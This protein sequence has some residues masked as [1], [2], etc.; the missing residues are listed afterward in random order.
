M[1]PLMSHAHAMPWPEPWERGERHGWNPA[2]WM[3]MAAE[4]GHRGRPRGRRGHGP[5][6]F[7]DDPQGGGGFGPPGGDSR[8]WHPRARGGPKV[9]R[10]DVRAALLAL[11]AE[12]PRN[13]YQIIQ[14]IA[15]RSDGVWRPSAG[16]V[17]P[18]L[19]QL[20]DEGLVQAV[21]SGTRRLFELTEEG[22]RYVEE[23][24]EE[25]A[26]LW[27]AVRDTVGQEAIDMR[28][29][30]RQVGMAAMQVLKVGSTSQIVE[31]RQVLTDTR[32]S[33]YRILAEDDTDGG[34]NGPGGPEDPE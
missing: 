32:R 1:E 12:E 4:H 15:E 17:Y 13:G 20:D 6:G 11:L 7:W 25:C 21:Q 22:R 10:G 34:D 33:L 31:M 16:S 18:A 5:S 2:R 27:E 30:V 23:H 19:Q 9:R 24:A 26:A 29:L 14:E 8:T 28:S 3:R